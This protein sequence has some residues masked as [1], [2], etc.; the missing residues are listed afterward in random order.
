MRDGQRGGREKGVNEGDEFDAIDCGLENCKRCAL[1]SPCGF[2]CPLPFC[3]PDEFSHRGT[4]APLGTAE[5]I[6]PKELLVR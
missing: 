5:V 1:H 3:V 2:L 4:E 6:C